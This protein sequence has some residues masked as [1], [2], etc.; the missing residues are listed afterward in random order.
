MAYIKKTKSGKWEA[1]VELGKDPA[2]GKRKYKTFEKKKD[3]NAWANRME[4]EVDEGIAINP[5]DY[6]IKEY[7]SWWLEDIKPSLSPTTYDG[8]DLICKTHIIP[9]IGAIKIINLKPMHIKTYIN[10]KRVR[11]RKDGKKGGLSERTLLHH[12]RVLNKALKDAVKLRLIRYN[13][14]DAIEAPTPK[15]K[16]I[17]ALTKKQL[18]NLLEASEGWIHNFIF[19]AA[20]TGMRRGELLGLRWSDVE[21]ENQMIRVSQTLVTKDGEGSVFKS[22]KTKS[23]Q[24]SIYITKKVIQVLKDHKSMQEKLKIH[25]GPDYENDLNLVFCK[26][27]GTRYYPTT[28][29]KKF[30]KIRKQVSL[31]NEVSIHTLRHTHATLLLKAGEHP[32]KVQ[33]RLGHSSISE[34]LDTYSHVTP[35]MQKE[36]AKKFDNIMS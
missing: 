2:T 23:S 6:T 29:N 5:T 10:N 1:Q 27:D 17:K 4:V 19:V 7:L 18:S 11:G 12:F 16:E 20:Y 33:E 21:F 13:P 3:A 35:N 9:T 15:K 32:R 36:T 24:R 25:L 14:G 31:L 8:Y 28:V 22:P 34:T 26:E 30:N